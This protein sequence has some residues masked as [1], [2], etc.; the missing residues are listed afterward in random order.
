MVPMAGGDVYRDR[1]MLM[2]A[3]GL[4]VQHTHH[5]LCGI[6]EIVFA[7][8]KILPP[9]TEP[10]NTNKTMFTLAEKRMASL[11]LSAHFAV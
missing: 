11:S 3:L 6:V 2:V 1:C 7:C 9:A 5:P 4:D 10:T 8:D